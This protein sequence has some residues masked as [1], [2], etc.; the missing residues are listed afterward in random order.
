M[1]REKIEEKIKE[2]KGEWTVDNFKFYI[3][4]DLTLW[5]KEG[6]TGC[7]AFLLKDYSDPKDWHVTSNM[8]LKFQYKYFNFLRGLCDILEYDLV[9]VD[10]IKSVHPKI[11]ALPDERA[12]GKV[13][14]YE[15]I[16]FKKKITIE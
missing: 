14:A 11:M 2:G 6:K 5:V 8:D 12:L 10:E 13:E 16:L 1:N 4:D 9:D 3:E 7:R 15:N